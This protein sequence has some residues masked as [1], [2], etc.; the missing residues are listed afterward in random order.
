MPVWRGC[1]LSCP[2]QHCPLWSPSD[3]L[4]TLRPA[5]ANVSLVPLRALCHVW[6]VWVFLMC[7]PLTCV[8]TWVAVSYR[9]EM[10]G[11]ETGNV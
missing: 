9:R 6:G 8:L 4:V 2:E 3:P 11:G 10:G 5:F 7:L 1:S